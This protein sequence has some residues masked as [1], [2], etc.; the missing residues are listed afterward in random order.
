MKRLGNYLKEYKVESV[1]APLLKMTEAGFELFVPLVIA[2]IIDNGIN[3]GSDGINHIYKMGAVLL[4]LAII[5]LICAITAQYF[6]AKAATGFSCSLR[7]G[8]F[9]HIQKLSFT[10]IDQKGTSTLI[11]RMTSDVNQVQNGVNMVL[12]L[13]LRSPIIVFGAMIMAFTVDVKAA[14]IFVVTIPLLTVAVAIIMY[15]TIPMYRKVQSKLDEV[16]LLTRENL[17]GARVVRAFCKEE[18]EIKTF[19]AESDALNDLQIYVGRISAIM[20]PVTFIIVNVATVVL[21]YTGAVRVDMGSLTQGQVVALVNYMAQILIELI[22]LAN[23]IIT[24]TKAIA[25]A[26]RIEAVLETESSMISGQCTADGNSDIAVEFDNV[27]MA[28]KDAS[29]DSVS[30]LS[31]RAMKGET[32]GIIGG[33]GSGKTTIVNMIPRFYDATAGVVR[34][35][36]RDVKDYDIETLRM[37]IGNVMQKAVLFKGT[38]RSNLLWGNEEA[39]E[40][41]L[42]DALKISQSYDFVSNMANGIDEEITQGGK[43]LSGGQRQR[44]SIARALVRKPEILILDDSSSALDYATESK[45]RQELS[46]LKNVTKFIISQRTSSIMHSDKIIVLDDGN[47]AGVGKHDW[48]LENCEVYKEIYDSQFV[49]KTE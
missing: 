32:I 4:F 14:L 47:V 28:Y 2:S 9:E 34:V 3:K 24:V 15:I 7:H 6:A 25:C 33:T 16:L 41:D 20:N 21:I 17:T 31:F 22:K 29:E 44:L 23:L 42:I 5:G 46:K 18:D 37:K 13:F 39:T 27:S 35:N 19:N 8:L 12:R 48:L 36:G 40:A 49:K 45:L 11:T 1:M 38:I 30:G 10:E 26:N 43:N